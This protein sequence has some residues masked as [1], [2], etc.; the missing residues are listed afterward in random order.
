MNKFILVFLL[1]LSGSAF[2]EGSKDHEVLQVEVGEGGFNLYL[3][4]SVF[5]S[6]IC[7]DGTSSNEN[8]IISF[9]QSDFPNGYAHMLSTALAAFAAKKK[10]SMWYKGCQA[11]PWRGRQMP[12]PVTLVIK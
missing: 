1:M 7:T 6:S 5:T 4:G 10:V 9:H 12:K 8:A 2:A 3:V 11:S